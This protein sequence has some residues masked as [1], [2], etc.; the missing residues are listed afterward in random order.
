MSNELAQKQLPSALERFKEKMSLKFPAAVAMITDLTIISGEQ[1][2]H[3]KGVANAISERIVEVPD[4][5]KLPWLNLLDSIVNNIGREY[6]RYFLLQLY[7]WHLNLS[8]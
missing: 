8:Y 2:K 6:V 3:G 4:E 7:S 1:R 5:Q